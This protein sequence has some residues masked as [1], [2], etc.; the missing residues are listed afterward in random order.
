MTQNEILVVETKMMLSEEALCKLHKNLLE[1][2]TTGVI[3]LPAGFYATI[4]PSDLEIVMKDGGIKN[5]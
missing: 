5:E 1:Q 4:V 2:K 3:V